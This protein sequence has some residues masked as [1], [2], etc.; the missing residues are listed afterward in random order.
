M[1]VSRM[2][3]ILQSFP[4]DLEVMISDGF[5]FHFFAGDYEILLLEELDGTTIVDIGV[6]GCRLDD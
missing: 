5:N 6:G 1:K 3:E 2:V 4:P